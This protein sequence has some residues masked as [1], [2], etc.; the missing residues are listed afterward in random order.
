MIIPFLK[1]KERYR[2]IDDK[3]VE[4]IHCHVISSKENIIV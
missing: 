1:K 2:Y 4:E 3:H